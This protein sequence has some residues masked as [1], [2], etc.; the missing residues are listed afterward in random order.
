MVQRPIPF[1][2]GVLVPYQGGTYLVFIGSPH[3]CDMPHP[4]TTLSNALLVK[5]IF[6]SDVPKCP[7]T[8]ALFQAWE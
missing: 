1:F 4:C 6:R 8:P 7:S 2:T 5:R 3:P